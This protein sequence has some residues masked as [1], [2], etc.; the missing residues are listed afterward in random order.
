MN[1]VADATVQREV[2]KLAAALARWYADHASIR[3]LWAM[4]SSVGIEILL[5]LEPTSDGDETLPIWLANRGDWATDLRLL[6]QREVQLRL[7]VLD[8]FGDSYVNHD[9][10]TI[11]QFSWRVSW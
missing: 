1:A 4:E 6:T 11:A 10:I 9:A 2:S 3:H 5:V 7:A 8:D